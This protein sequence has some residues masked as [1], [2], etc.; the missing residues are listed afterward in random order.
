MVQKRVIY[1]CCHVYLLWQSLSSQI[2]KVC[3]VIEWSQKFMNVS[4]SMF[5]SIDRFQL[6]N[7]FIF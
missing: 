1:G 4:L 6:L 2:F 5:S 3:I 7:F